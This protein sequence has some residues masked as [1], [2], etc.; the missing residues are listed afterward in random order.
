MG[1]GENLLVEDDVVAHAGSAPV[2]FI[3]LSSKIMAP[4]TRD[5]LTGVNDM[6]TMSR[7]PIH[8]QIRRG[9]NTN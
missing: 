3:E 4:L 2:L 8:D 6:R 7:K 5:M 1:D 9:N